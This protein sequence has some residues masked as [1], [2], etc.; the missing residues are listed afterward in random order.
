MTRDNV[1]Q[2]VV[3]DGFWP[4]VTG[5]VLL[6]AVVLD[7]STRSRPEGERAA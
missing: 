1:Q 5:A 7:A 3:K 6:G 4:V 2:T